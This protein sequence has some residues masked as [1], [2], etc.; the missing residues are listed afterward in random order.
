MAKTLGAHDYLVKPDNFDAWIPLAKGLHE[1]GCAAIKERSRTGVQIVNR[2]VVPPEP[3]R[4]ASGLARIRSPPNGRPRREA[5][6]GPSRRASRGG[7]GV[8]ARG[9]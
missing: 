7:R 2:M 8:Y 4:S 6:H 5:D 1:S 3:L 9:R